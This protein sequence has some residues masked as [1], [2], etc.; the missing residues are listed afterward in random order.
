MEPEISL[1]LE[2]A[3]KQIEADKLNDRLISLLKENREHLIC[4]LC[5][6]Y[7]EQDVRALSMF[8]LI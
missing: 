1:L 7:C 8:G 6:H 5:N 4:Y 3:T 2:V